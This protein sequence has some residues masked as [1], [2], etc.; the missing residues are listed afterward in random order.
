MSRPTAKN[1]EEF[2][3]RFYDSPHRRKAE[4]L[5]HSVGGMVAFFELLHSMRR[6]YSGGTMARRLL[7]HRHQLATIMDLRP[8][9]VLGLYRGFKLPPH[10]VSGEIQEGAS[11]ELALTRNH[12]LSSWTTTVAA[13]NRFSGGGRGKIGFVV[14]LSSVKGVVPVLAPPS[15]TQKWFNDFYANVIGRS[16]RPTEGEYLI[17]APKVKVEVVRVKRK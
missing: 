9:A 10:F 14:R 2:Q 15:H 1:L 8:Q 16:Y 6:W 11:G 3:S 5:A 12:G 4:D 7:N 17:L 13:A